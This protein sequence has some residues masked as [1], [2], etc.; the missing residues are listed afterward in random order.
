MKH[1]GCL[2][3][4]TLMMGYGY[5]PFL[6]E[7]AVKP[8]VFLTSTFAFRNAEAGKHFFELAYGMKEKEPGEVPGLIYSRLNNPDLEILENRLAVWENAETS[9]VFS[10]GMAAISSTILAHVSP[11]EEVVATTPVYGG[12]HYFLSKIMPRWGM[13]CHWIP[14]GSTFV[15]ELEQRL[16]QPDHGVRMVYIETPANPSNQ[17]TDLKRCLDLC[18][19]HGTEERPIRLVVDNTFMG[20]VFQQPLKL[21]ADITVYSATKFIGG[22]SDLVAGA[23]LGPQELLAPISEMRTIFG[24]MA[25]PFTGW[26]LMR[27][28]ETV[29]IRMRQQQANARAIVE[30]LKEQDCVE[31]VYYPGELDDEQDRIWR[32]QCSGTGSLISFDIRGGEAEAFRVLDS[33]KHC[34]LAVSLGGTETLI[35][36]PATMTHSDMSPEDMQHAAISGSMIRLSVGIEHVDDI[37]ED[38]RQALHT[39]R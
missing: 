20:P 31:K 9:L 30:M 3:P 15:D 14:A 17:M 27:S 16:Q 39:V 22:H 5:D 29:G 7:G 38:L 35:Q 24:N 33:V 37:I 13:R 21:G 32:N 12:T 11:G 10:S 1:K 8:P 26:L 18:R 6:S 36:H 23:V 25:S 28:L 19:R 2:H 4:E 34:K